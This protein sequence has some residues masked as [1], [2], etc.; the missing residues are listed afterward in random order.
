MSD[1]SLVSRPLRTTLNTL[2]A[3]HSASQSRHG[4]SFHGHYRTLSLVRDPPPHLSLC[5]CVKHPF[6]R[7]KSRF[8]DTLVFLTLSERLLCVRVSESRGVRLSRSST[9]SN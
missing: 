9:F 5:F 4:P 3:S 8:C 2:N 1:Q 6:I 7:D